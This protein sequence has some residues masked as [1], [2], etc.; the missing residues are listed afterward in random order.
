LR[1]VLSLDLNCARL[2]FLDLRQDHREH[3]VLQLSRDLA[4]VD[5]ARKPEA[6]RLRRLCLPLAADGGVELLA[7]VRHATDSTP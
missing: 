6:P 5:P 1:I 3:A 4:L 7:I 2:R